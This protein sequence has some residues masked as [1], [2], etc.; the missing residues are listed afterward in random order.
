[1]LVRFQSVVLLVCSHGENVNIK[2]AKKILR[3]IRY[4]QGRNKVSNRAVKDIQL[5]PEQLVEIFNKQGG[6][7]YWSGLELDE[8]YNFI[9]FHPFAISPDRLDNS[10]PYTTE[11][12]VLCRR[13]FN[14]GRIAFDS[15]SFK[16]V[17]KKMEIEYK[18]N[19]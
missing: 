13:L 10:A 19:I 14:L 5:T 9:K 18:N 11:N 3:G 16:A 15:A 4:S 2:T 6:K 8:N 7:C 12:V 1:M 17:M